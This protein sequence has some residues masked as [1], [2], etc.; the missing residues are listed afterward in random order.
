MTLGSSWSK[1][2]AKGICHDQP[3]PSGPSVNEGHGPSAQLES[4]TQMF[5][6][7]CLCVYSSVVGSAL[8]LQ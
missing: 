7:L 1:Q 5:M 3:V 4:L 8:S 6:G 2:E